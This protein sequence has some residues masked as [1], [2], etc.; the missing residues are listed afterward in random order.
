MQ[1]ISPD[2]LEIAMSETLPPHLEGLKISNAKILCGTTA[3]GIF[4]FQDLYCQKYHACFIDLLPTTKQKILLLKHTPE[5]FLMI[6]LRQTL[7]CCFNSMPAVRYPEWS[8]NLY[9]SEKIFVE[10]NLQALKDSTTFVLFI[11]NDA[12]KRLSKYYPIIQRF[13]IDNNAK[14]I[15]TKLIKSN[16]ICNFQVMDLI[17]DLQANNFVN[18]KKY[19]HLINAGFELLSKKNLPKQSA[20]DENILQRI[21]DLKNFMLDNIKENY[22]RSELCKRASLSLYHFEKGFSKIYNASPFLLLRYYRMST[23]R[24]QKKVTP[25]KELASIYNYSYTSLIRT[26]QSVYK[27]HPTLHENK[28]VKRPSTKA[29]KP[30]IKN[31]TT[32]KRGK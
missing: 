10:I 14:E 13:Y 21:Y 11:P 12:I 20:I 16:P 24:Q 5:F 4:L 26:Y 22:T 1:L 27:V 19:I 28:T 2:S 17:R 30:K 18:A 3:K 29:L 7:E 9:H 8:I 6:Q 32:P 25:L 15:T 31:R 23:I